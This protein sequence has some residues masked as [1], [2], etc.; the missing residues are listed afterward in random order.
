MKVRT[1][2]AYHLFST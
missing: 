2:K 1:K